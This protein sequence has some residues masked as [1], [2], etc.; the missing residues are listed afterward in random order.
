ML[1][2]A[3][4]AQDAPSFRDEVLP[5]LSEH[6][7]QC[8]GFDASAR[9][10]KDEPLRLDVFEA[11]TAPRG[12][13]SRAIAPGK[14]AASSIIAR[15][16]SADP[17]LLMPPPSAHKPLSPKQI[18]VLERWIAA[19]APYQRHWSFEP[20]PAKVP[21]PQPAT[22]PGFPLRSPVDAF[23]L[24]RLQRENL[25]P[26]PEASRAMWL[27]RV[28]F[29][30]TGLPP[31]QAAL[32]AFLRDATPLAYENA[33]DRLLAMPAFGERWGLHWLEVARYADSFGYQSDLDTN[34]WPWRDWVIRAFNDNLPWNEFVTWQLAGDLLPEPTRDQRL[35]TAFNRIHRMTQ[36]G[37]SV[38]AEFRQ[39]SV[40]D[41]VHTFGTAFLGLTMECARCHDHRYDPISM[42]DYYS[43]GSYFNSIDEWGLLPGKTG[44]NPRPVLL[45]PTP[46][47]EQ[48]IA[49]RREAVAKAENTLR[50]THASRQAAFGEWL[51]QRPPE[52]LLADHTGW[53]PLDEA[54]SNKLANR[55]R[56]DKPGT[57]NPA[58]SWI[59]RPGGRAVRFTGDD[60]VSF[61]KGGASHQHD[62][63]SVAFLLD[64]GPAA[65]RKLVFHSSEG[66]DPGFNGY[67][68]LL[69]EGRLRWTW[70][71]QWPGDCISV[72][73][74]AS[75]QPGTWTHVT[76]TYD[77]S[78]KAAGLAVYLDGRAAELEVV[79]DKLVK[80][81][82]S[83][84]A[85]HFG[86][87]FRDN[88]LTGGAVAEVHTFDR[89][90]TPLEAA[91]IHDGRALTDLLTKPADSLTQD[92][93]ESLRLYWL[94]AVD[95]ESRAATAALR[96]ARVALREAFDPVREVPVMEEDP[97]PRP[98]FVLER[99][100]YD[101]KR[102][103]PAPRRV[104]DWLPPL[105]PDAPADRLGLARWLL[106]SD[107]PLFA[108]VTVNRFWQEMFGRGLVATS[109][110]FG[111]QGTPPSHPELLDW[112]ARDFI[113]SGWDVKRLLRG[114]ALSSTYRQ[115]SAA[116]P[117]SRSRDPENRLLSRGPAKR[118]TGEMLRDAALLSGGLLNPQLGGPPSKPPQP[119]GSMWRALNSFLPEYQP[120][121]GPAARR[122]S[123][124]TFWRRT[125]PPPNMVVFDAATRDVCAVGRQTTNTPLQPLVTLNDPQFVEAAGGLGLRLLAAPGGPDERLAW[126][127]REVSGRAPDAAET[128]L[129]RELFE[130]QRARFAADPAA[131]AAFL[132]ASAMATPEGIEPPA[133]AAAAVTASALL[134]L[135][136]TLMLR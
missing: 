52:P 60:P 115:A 20:L 77:G 36:E 136:A 50:E 81:C 26:A 35:A 45:L 126:A 16:R 17:A 78:S 3:P 42:G 92:E 6:C 125:T 63:L 22:Q 80:N 76:V 61:D 74:K 14:P 10:P 86:Q 41:R 117:A 72:R 69:E 11:A 101:G 135:D 114:L 4:A 108:R 83:T 102:L 99:G 134:N 88:G 33:V 56:P 119:P 1:S 104:P 55:V 28:S 29:D 85:I 7:F 109:D 94:S 90:I 46:Q 120:D 59:D 54:P 98:A 40:S 89:A 27:R 51:A 47:Q 12:D 106:R 131:A 130:D 39:Q 30:F 71:R 93:R 65:P 95:N 113:D 2:G 129:L 128:G 110:N 5:V 67:E 123:L 18:D 43:L 64:P 75:L 87:R 38:E 121:T 34:A 48:D 116:S 122:R 37:G 58:N 9:F 118:L 133:A 132:K 66:A 53:H 31:D 103:A 84:G 91:Q 105:P 112:L 49:T 21:V 79:R 124:Y 68:L 32:D 111:L 15:M 127:F 44:I 19:G 13:G 82:G 57:F 70:Q 97:E 73:T 25:T 100:A 8:H 107:H 24:D 96:Q 62:P 23:V